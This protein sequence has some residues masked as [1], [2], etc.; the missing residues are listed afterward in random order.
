MSSL[1]I[2]KWN[3]QNTLD[4]GQMLLDIWHHIGKIKSKILRRRTMRMKK[5][6]EKPLNKPSFSVFLSTLLLV[7]S[8][9]HTTP[10]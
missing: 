3:E 9:C 6:V 4:S 10:H 8:K 5:L 1:R 2:L 7:E